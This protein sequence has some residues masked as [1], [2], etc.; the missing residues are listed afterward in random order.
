MGWNR[1]VMGVLFGGPPFMSRDGVAARLTS[2]NTGLIIWIWAGGCTRLTQVSV[3]SLSAGSRAS[4]SAHSC[5]VPRAPSL[6]DR[7]TRG[8]APG[9]L[10]I[11]TLLAD[12]GSSVQA[13]TEFDLLF[14]RAQGPRPNHATF[15][16]ASTRRRISASPRRSRRVRQ[17]YHHQLANTDMLN[18]GSPPRQI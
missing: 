17:S 14:R 2:M 12:P 18:Q 16:L 4:K 7:V 9:I 8:S 3:L 10:V 11:A 13:L 15:P 5:P 6:P 1:K